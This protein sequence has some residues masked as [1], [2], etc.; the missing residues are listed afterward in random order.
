MNGDLSFDTS[1]GS[2]VVEKARGRLSSVKLHTG[3]G[4][5]VYRADS[6]SAM[7]E[8]RDIITG[9]GSVSICL[10]QGFVGELDAHT[11]D[12]SIRSD[13]SL[14]SPPSGENARRTLRGKIGA[15]G[16]VL[17]IRTGHGSIKLRT[18]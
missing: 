5:V 3:D 14:F 7:T 18:N 6:D 1:D 17:R 11:G 10:S 8:D 2:V 4:S 9:D 16:K 13:L 15:G 12:G